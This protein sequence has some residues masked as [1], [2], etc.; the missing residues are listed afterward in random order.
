MPS[1]IYTAAIDTAHDR[2]LRLAAHLYYLDDAKGLLEA[3]A[4]LVAHSVRDGA[5]DDQLVA[6]L[7]EN[8]VCY[9]PTLMREVSTFV[10]E[11]RPEW[12]DDPF[13]LKEVD[14]AV[15]ETDQIKL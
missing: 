5:V 9:C 15:I 10:Y 7:T 2:G 12:F 14:S 11:S 13:F 8:N 1:D 3:G 6:L 4:D